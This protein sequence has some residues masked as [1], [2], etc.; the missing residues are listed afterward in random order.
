[1]THI[2]T[3]IV[4]VVIAMLLSLVFMYASL[5]SMISA[6]KSNTERVLDSFVMEN[7]TYI[8]NSIKNGH[9]FTASIDAY[10]YISKTSSELSLDFSGGMLYNRNE[11]GGFNFRMT[12][13]Q[14]SFTVSNTLNLTTTYDLL[15]PINFAGKRVL[16][17]RVP[18]TVKVSYNLK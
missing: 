5:M 11:Q 10:Y 12:N 16:E 17:L 2:K 9:D 7:A 14:T 6:T 18:I 8:Y 13:P 15:F 4:V 3:A 1:M